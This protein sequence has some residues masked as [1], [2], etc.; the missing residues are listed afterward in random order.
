MSGR[1]EA[2]ASLEPQLQDLQTSWACCQQDRPEG[3]VMAM[4]GTPSWGLGT[5][6]KERG[7]LS[8]ALILCGIDFVIHHFLWPQM[9]V[10]LLCL[11]SNG[12][13]SRHRCKFQSILI[14][15]RPSP[16]SFFFWTLGLE[17]G[18]K[19]S[20]CPPYPAGSFLI[21]SAPI[22]NLQGVKLFKVLVKQ[23]PDWPKLDVLGI[24][25]E[26]DS[27]GK[28]IYIALLF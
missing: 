22:S 12:M 7:T 24:K 5:H 17:N 15:M 8:W 3:R 9:C 28:R 19:G 21:K 10:G 16:P 13:K 25:D 2:R 11:L 6:H 18:R 4:L 20:L 1:A 26:G 14:K 27:K 23:L